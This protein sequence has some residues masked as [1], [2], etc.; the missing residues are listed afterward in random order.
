MDIYIFGLGHIGLPLAASI[1]LCGKQVHG[2]DINPSIINNISNGTISQSEYYNGKHISKIVLELINKKLLTVST[3]FIRQRNEPSVF[4]ITVGSGMKG[5]I[6]SINAVLDNIIPVLIPQDLIIVRSTIIPGTCENII[7]PRLKS[8]NTPIYLTYCPETISESHAFEEF[9]GNNLVLAGIDEK[10]FAVAESF[11]NSIKPSH[12]FK[13]SNIHTAEM[14]KIAQNICRDVDI[15]F[16]NELSEAT[17]AL[18][19]DIYELQY[20][21]NTHPRINLLSPG[22][23]VGGYCIP[24]ALSYLKEALTFKKVPL[25]LMNTARRINNEKP[26]KIVNFIIKTLK[27]SDID[28]NEASVA[29]IGLAMKDNCNDCRLSPALDIIHNLIKLGIK[30]T[31]YDPIVPLSYPFQVSSFEE[32]IKNADCLVITARQPNLYYDMDKIKLLT[33]KPLIIIDTKNVFPESS[34]FKIYNI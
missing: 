21:A 15:A 33:S 31:V 25:E 1:G 23:G 11:F 13:A 17:S 3:C 9:F 5:D 30:V 8:T 26:N 29:V 19:V 14:V 10:S 20:L 4:I 6:S 12:I 27:D 34:D 2:I 18:N 7:F 22:P 16:M 28:L 32:C 24:N